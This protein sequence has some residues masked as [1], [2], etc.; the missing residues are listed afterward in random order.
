MGFLLHIL[1]MTPAV[2]QQDS[3]DS[4]IVVLVFDRAARNK[5]R[6]VMEIYVVRPGDSVDRIAQEFSVPAES[7]I[8]NN[9]LVFPYPLAVGICLYL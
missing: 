2:R 3:G 5:R 9:Q 6:A 4:G 1:F 7:I 8:W